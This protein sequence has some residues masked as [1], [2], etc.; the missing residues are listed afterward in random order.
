MK[1]LKV[2]IESCWKTKG[3]WGQEQPRCPELSRVIH[4]RNC[5]VF[6][7]VGRNLL[8]RELPEEYLSE[9]TQVFA[10]K[11]EDKLLGTI[12]VVIFR[13]KKEWLAL[14]AQLFAEIVKIERA[15]RIP[16]RNNKIL[17]GVVNIHGDIQLCVSLTQ[18]LGIEANYDKTKENRRAYKRMMVV[19]RDGERWVF[20]VDEIEGIYRVHP[21]ILQN[22]P[23]TVSKS[24]SAF[25][26]GIFK[27][28]DKYVAL[29]DEELLLY[30]LTR[31]VQ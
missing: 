22:V 14:P 6:T 17:M 15:H 23:V 12:A 13:L 26:K 19:N 4:C 20:L 30:K 18:L 5:E 3:V 24:N 28:Q 10:A 21:N 31:S 27:W 25:T 11:K 16:H 7:Q 8:E 1:D 2:K 9:W 29:L